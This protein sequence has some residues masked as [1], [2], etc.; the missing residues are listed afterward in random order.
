[1]KNTEKVADKI[2]A[3]LA[4]GLIST[5]QWRLWIPR[6][7]ADQ[8]EIVIRNARALSDGIEE[9]I[10]G[11]RVDEMIDLSKYESVVE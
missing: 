5:A 10:N 9:H 8:P 3:L 2:I 1:M 4:D 7:L 6:H 11:N